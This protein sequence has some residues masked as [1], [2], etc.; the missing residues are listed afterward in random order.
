MKLRGFSKETQ[1][2]YV[3]QNKLFLNFINKLPE[4]VTEQDIK[5]YLAQLISDAGQAPRTISLK[6]SALK[7]FYDEVL[8]KG[9]VNIK[10]PKIPQSHPVYLTKEEVRTLID[11]AGSD[12]TK[13][14]I[15]LLYSSG[16]RVSECANLKVDDIDVE[17]KM[18]KVT[19]G[20]GSKDRLTIVSQTVID[21]LEKYLQTLELNEKFIFP[22]KT[23]A[24]SVRNVQKA[25]Q[26]A[27]KK[28][29]INK[30]VSPHVLRHSFATH[31][32]EAGTDI[33]IIQELLGHAQLST[34]QIYTHVS[35]EQLK[36]VKSPLD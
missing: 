20:K 22:G 10:T 17:N 7:F 30:K 31:L 27:G 26:L 23:G 32:L 21:H 14:F 29:G 19:A 1:R 12:K 3:R 2:T 28:A 24:I 6:K 8:N 15:E 5:D 18:I 33:R 25:I 35:K 11:S 9:I 16:L 36:K 4:Q 13:L 34:T